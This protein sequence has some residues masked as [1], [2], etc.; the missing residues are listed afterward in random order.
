MTGARLTSALKGNL[1]QDMAKER[2]AM[3]RAVL[4]GVRAQTNDLKNT[5]RRRTRAAFKGN[6]IARAWRSK[7]YP[8]DAINAA[9]FVWTKVPN[10]IRMAETGGTIRAPR[11]RFLMIPLKGAGGL[12]S[13]DGTKGSAIRRRARIEDFAKNKNLRFIPL[14]GGRFLVVRA[15]KSRSTPLF[16]LV[17]QVK[18][19]RRPVHFH[20]E[21]ER[22][23]AGVPTQILRRMPA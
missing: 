8:N 20:R 2:S 5:M 11:G 10:I 4:G 14:S 12:R 3:R 9:G 6:K 15:T 21:A 19:R 18:V 13:Y 7:V 22:A 23:S 1:K 17:R 16:L